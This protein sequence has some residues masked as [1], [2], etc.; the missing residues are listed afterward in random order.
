MAIKLE[1]PIKKT[2]YNMA[3]TKDKKIK[4]Y[5]LIPSVPITLVDSKAK[6]KQKLKTEQV[7]KKVAKKNKLEIICEP[8]DF[9]L[10]EKMQD[11]LKDSAEDSKEIASK[12]AGYTVDYLTAEMEIPHKHVWVIGVTIPKNEKVVDLKD[13]AK[14][15]VEDLAER[16]FSTLGYDLATDEDW[17]KDFKAGEQEIYQTLQ[18]IQG[19]RLSD[20][21]FFYLQRGQFLRH[22]PHQKSQV[23][24]SRALLNVTDTK[25]KVRSGY[26]EL[27]SPY[28]KSFVSILPIAD[29]PVIFNE[30]HI[31]ELVQRFNYPVGYQVLTDPLD[32]SEVKRR[33]NLNRLRLKNIIQ[34]A[35]NQDSV[36]SDDVLLRKLSVDDIYKKLDNDDLFLDTG[37]FFIVSASNVNQLNARKQALM[38]Y[39]QSMGISLSEANDDQPYLFQALLYGSELNADTRK[40]L[41]IYT[42]KGLAEN[43]LFT[44]TFSGTK[45]GHYIGR[46]DNFAGRWDTIEEAVAAS[47]I[48]VLYNATIGNK[49]GILGKV[50]KNP[51]IIITGE[52]GQGKTYL[53]QMLFFQA[54]LQNIKLL[55]VDPKQEFR[56]HYMKKINDPTFRKKYPDRVAQ[57]ERFNFVTL[58]PSNKKNHGVLDPIV[59]LDEYDAVETAKS[60]LDY[61]GQGK[62]TNFEKTVISKAV[63][64]TVAERLSGQKVGFKQVL[65]KLMKHEDKRAKEAGEFLYEMSQG[66]ILDLAFSDGETK[67]LDYS[68]RVTILEVAGL[69]LPKEDAEQ[70]SEHERNSIALM[71]ALGSFCQR[72]GDQNRDEQ[73]MEFF[74]EAW[75]L[76]QSAEGKKVI[77]SM[78]R[79]GRSQNNTLV[80]ISQSVND[81]KTDDDT[82]GFGTIF[83]FYEKNER[84][85]ILEHVGLEV[86]DTNLE[87]IDNMI[88]AQCLMS[89]VYGNKNIISIHN[90]FP[91]LHELFSP[92]KSTASSLAENKYA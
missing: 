3:L 23:I 39:F 70:I 82:T 57:I 29:S 32:N 10:L 1:Y 64:A 30:S 41:H 51:H 54:T 44:T 75:I 86:T 48:T 77:K 58:D 4:A 66:T 62:F 67:G 69:S 37:H 13:F 85:M 53:A 2:H 22:I 52:T 19:R 50:T 26:L 74:D 35:S 36:Q 63:K 46:V 83:A 16:A 65:E 92:M 56:K 91:D 15:K 60:I 76:M 61:L 90:I 78:R 28:G 79:V 6:E 31:A 84:E 40:W 43:M 89:D 8:Q 49:E 59:I 27:I 24:A 12:S 17:Y 14:K 72:F 55:Y 5:Y 38:S 25:I 45:V 88:P 11:L 68:E 87:W 34:E 42:P 81:A 18:T 7:L 9:L 73:T 71:F 80:L 20:E 21:D 33:A 47:R